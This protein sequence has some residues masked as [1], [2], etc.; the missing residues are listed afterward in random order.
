M[1]VPIAINIRFINVK[2]DRLLSWGI[3]TKFNASKLRDEVRAIQRPSPLEA[4]VDT[5]HHRRLSPP[6][7]MSAQ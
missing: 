6:D 1:H 4:L 5:R 7:T 2:L 3:C